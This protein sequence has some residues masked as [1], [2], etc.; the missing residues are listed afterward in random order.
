MGTPHYMAPEQ[1]E[2]P[3]EIDHRADIYSLGVVFYEMLTGE[4]PLGRFAPPS[5]KVQVDVR[6]DEV[7]LRALEKEP[8]RR[9]QSVSELKTDVESLSDPS[10]HPSARPGISRHGDPSRPP[11]TVGRWLAWQ[12]PALIG[13]IYALSFLFPAY[14]VSGRPSALSIEPPPTLSGYYCFINALNAGQP[15]WLANPLLWLGCLALLIRRSLWA[16]VIGLIAVPLAL[17]V[18]FA[19]DVPVYL[20]DTFLAGYW[21]WVA[22]MVLLAGGGLY[23][24]WRSRRQSRAGDIK[25][26]LPEIGPPKPD[27]IRDSDDP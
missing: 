21:M 2:R 4:L 7:V 26:T 27:P 1:I 18:F 16:G 10:G 15:Y 23:G 12:L 17:S 11:S 6:L 13:A 24:W 5:K 22:S 9:Y 14:K 19:G 3:L 20:V 8:K 25:T